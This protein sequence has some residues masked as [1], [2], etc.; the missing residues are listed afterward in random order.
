MYGAVIAINMY[1]RLMINIEEPA[2]VAIFLTKLTPRVERYKMI[3]KIT[4]AAIVNKYIL[5]LLIRLS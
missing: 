1:K 4:N 2:I 5:A 3:K